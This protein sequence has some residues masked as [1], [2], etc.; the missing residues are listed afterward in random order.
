MNSEQA[1]GDFRV[2]EAI[3]EDHPLLQ[4]ILDGSLG[5]PN[6][7]VYGMAADELL[8]QNRVYIA[9]FQER[10]TACV[11]ATLTEPMV[12]HCLHVIPEYRRRGHAGTLLT[13]A[14][15]QM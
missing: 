5:E 9:F 14:I 15:Q 4:S 1:E 12:L 6:T 3:T 2:R 7:R 11:M 10:P 8:R 13:S